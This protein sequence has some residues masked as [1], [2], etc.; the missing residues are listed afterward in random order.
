M[1]WYLEL[2]KKYAVFRGRARLKE[3]W[4]FVLFSTLIYSAFVM[5][6]RVGGFRDVIMGSGPLSIL[7]L[8]AV[9]LPEFAVTARRLHDASHSGWWQ[10]M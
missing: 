2:L 10:L 8:L 3:Y 7:Y 9:S 4:Y 1:N 5:I 6:D